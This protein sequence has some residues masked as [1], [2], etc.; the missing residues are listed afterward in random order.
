MEYKEVIL[1]TAQTFQKS[2]DEVKQM[3][4]AISIQIEPMMDK[5]RQL[6]KSVEERLQ[7][8]KKK[9]NICVDRKIYSYIKYKQPLIDK[10]LKINLIRNN[11]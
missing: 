6:I 3:I 4:E 1:R 2:F 8:Y 7:E 10:R 11:C 9:S 5:L